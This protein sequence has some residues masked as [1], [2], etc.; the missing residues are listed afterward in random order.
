MK[1]D[2]I[3][4]FE[5]ARGYHSKFFWSDSSRIN[6]ADNFKIKEV[7]MTTNHKDTIRGMHFQESPVRQEKVLTCVQGSAKV[8]LLCADKENKDYGKIESMILSFPDSKT[9]VFAPAGYALGYRILEDN[10][11]MLYLANGDFSPESDS[12]FSPLTED[13]FREFLVEGESIN[14]LKKKMILSE[15]DFNLPEFNFSK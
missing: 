10:T 11:K 3:K 5:D 2:D 14:E 12:G 4:F 13:I 15:K 8:V 9:Q 6:T 7:F 1:K